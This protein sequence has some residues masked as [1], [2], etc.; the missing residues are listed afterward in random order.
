LHF[1]RPVLLLRFLYKFTAAINYKPLLC[2]NE[3][4]RK[5]GLF[6]QATLKY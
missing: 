4:H 6:A 5:L 1:N 2:E 3:I